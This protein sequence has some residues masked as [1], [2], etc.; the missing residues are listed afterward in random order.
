LKKPIPQDSHDSS[1]R[2]LDQSTP[3]RKIATGLMLFFLVCIVAV[4]GYKD[5]LPELASKFTAKAKRMTYRGVTV[6]S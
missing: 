1:P 6:E 4:I 2:R 5:D 3:L